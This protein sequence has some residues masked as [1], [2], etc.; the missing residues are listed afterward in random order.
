[1]RSLTFDDVFA[2]LSAVALSASDLVRLREWTASI[3]HPDECIA[4]IEQAARG[5]PCTSASD[6]YCRPMCC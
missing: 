5:R 1:M 2:M 6:R 4:L 3:A